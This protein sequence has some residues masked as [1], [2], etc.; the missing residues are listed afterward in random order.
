[1]KAQKLLLI[2]IYPMLKK[3]RA[4]YLFAEK[5]E[6]EKYALLPAPTQVNIGIQTPT[7]KE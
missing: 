7:Q 6:P 2:Q 5:L 3:K 4:G 1:M